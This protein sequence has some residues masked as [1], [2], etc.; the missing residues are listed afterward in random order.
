VGRSTFL[1]GRVV[2]PGAFLTEG[3][4]EIKCADCT[5]GPASLALRPERILLAAESLSGLDNAL[6][7]EVE[8]VSYLG[9]NVDVHVRLSPKER[10]IV[11][12]P[13]RES[14][15]APKAGDRVHVGWSTSS[16]ALFPGGREEAGSH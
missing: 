10:V 11:Q 3:G 9:A 1:E 5:A 13:N 14:S 15:V 7:G 8:F 2:S 12:I 16:G 6:P 4:L